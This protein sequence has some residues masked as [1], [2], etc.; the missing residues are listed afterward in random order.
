[1]K[2]IVE[3]LTKNNETISCME[4]CTGGYIANEITNV[5]GASKVFKLSYVTYCNDAKVLIGVDEELI[6]KYTVYSKEVAACMARVCSENTNATYGIGITG[7]L[8]KENDKIYIGMYNSKKDEIKTYM[9][10]AGKGDRKAK[11]ENVFCFVKETFL[12]FLFCD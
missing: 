7:E 3:A 12:K 10:E 5:E 8:G 2:E 9:V 11:K 1:M 6:N 4:S